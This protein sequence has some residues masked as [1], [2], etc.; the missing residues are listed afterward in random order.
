MAIFSILNVN[1]QIIYWPRCAN[2]IL[3]IDK[4]SELLS[5][6]S[7]NSY[8]G[9][10][11]CGDFN[12]DISNYDNKKN[13]LNLLNS[14]TSQSLIPII[15]KPSRITNQ[16]ATF[17][18]NIFINQPNGSGSDILVSDISDHLPLFIIKRNQFTKKSCQQNRNMKYRLINDSTITIIC[19]L[20]FVLTWIIFQDPTIVQALWNP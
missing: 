10:I 16:T 11:L 9:I 12:L 20:Y 19:N 18:D 7:G 17:I 1:I 2:V 5:I 14:L 4:L 8:D 3:F 6:I 15:T 13:T